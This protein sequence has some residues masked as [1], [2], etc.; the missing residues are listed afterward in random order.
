[1]MLNKGLHRKSMWNTY[2]V[3]NSS[4]CNVSNLDLNHD[5]ASSKFVDINCDS[6]SASFNFSDVCLQNESNSVSR[7]LDAYKKHKQKGFITTLSKCDR[8]KILL[9]FHYVF[10][11]VI[12]LNK[13]VLFFFMVKLEFFMH[14]D[15]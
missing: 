8:C 12:N 4:C 5:C 1:M 6:F 9:I 2:L 7:R 3:F 11:V 10:K 14:C 13:T 15:L